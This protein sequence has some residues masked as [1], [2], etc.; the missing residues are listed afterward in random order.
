[1]QLYDRVTSA[2]NRQHNTDYE[3]CRRLQR[4]TR[5]LDAEGLA[6]DSSLCDWLPRSRW[7][8]RM[9]HQGISRYRIGESP[10]NGV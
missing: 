8:D 7:R 3:P 4:D 1:M 10:S 9:C 2:K 5:A 6:V